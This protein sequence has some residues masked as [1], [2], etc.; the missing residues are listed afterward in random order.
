MAESTKEV[1]AGRPKTKTKGESLATATKP[2]TKQDSKAV[3]VSSTPAAKPRFGFFSGLM[4][5]S[6]T[7][8]DASGTTRPKNPSMSRFFFGMSLYMVLALAAQ[9]GLTFAFQRLP[10]AYS[11]KA[12]F[13]LPVLGGVTTYLLVWMIVLIAILFALYKFNVLPRSLSQP[14]PATTAKVDPKA[15]A[16]PITKVKPTPVE[17]PNDDAYA[18]VKARIRAERRK[19]RKS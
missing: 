11:T 15:K 2:T 18:R 8:T 14:R 1:L 16:A 12:L 3:M 19:G 6:K 7:S 5:G 10:S 4:G 13:T 9:F 17:G